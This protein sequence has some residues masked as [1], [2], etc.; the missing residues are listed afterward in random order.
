[1]SGLA[2]AFLQATTIIGYL[3]TLGQKLPIIITTFDCDHYIMNDKIFNS[4]END[5]NSNMIEIDLLKT[6]S[7]NH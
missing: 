1:M 6:V 2:L 7:L 5:L 3:F 4:F